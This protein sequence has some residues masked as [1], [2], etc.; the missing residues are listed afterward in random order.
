MSHRFN[1]ATPEDPFGDVEPKV[2][3]DDDD[4][5][6]LTSCEDGNEELSPEEQLLESLESD[7]NLLT[8]EAETI[9]AHQPRAT[10]VQF[11]VDTRRLFNDYQQHGSMARLKVD[12]EKFF[13]RGDDGGKLQLADPEAEK[14]NT[15]PGHFGEVFMINNTS[16]DD[17]PKYVDGGLRVHNTANGP[18]STF[19]QFHTVDS[20]SIPYVTNLP[21][22]P[23]ATVLRWPGSLQ[24][25]R[26]VLSRINQILSIVDHESRVRLFHHISKY[27]PSPVFRLGIAQHVQSQYSTI[28]ETSEDHY[29]GLT[30]ETRSFLRSVFESTVSLNR[31]EIR[32]LAQACRIAEESVKIFWEDFSTS[33]RG[34]NA[35]K[36]FM[37]A[38]EV[39]KSKEARLDNVAAKQRSASWN[40]YEQRRMA[41]AREAY[42][43]EELERQQQIATARNRTV[44]Q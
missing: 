11:T 38:R 14:A 40:E 21:W 36:L 20:D 5:E 6:S 26:G 44:D 23:I 32:M 13:D 25:P 39:E 37:T 1:L 29:L 19:N 24:W 33:R 16:D 8:L 43:T 34:Y 31:T 18:K 42:N 3:D 7:L 35:M 2:P 41:E 17:Q 15:D 27:G 9:I 12:V 10:Q 22:D 28:L 30:P 4:T